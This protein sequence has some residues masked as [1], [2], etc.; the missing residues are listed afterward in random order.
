M[1][2]ASATT[3][4]IIAL[5]SLEIVARLSI[6]EAELATL[7][8]GR[9]VPRGAGLEGER[10]LLN[11]VDEIALAAGLAA[12]PVYV[13]T[14][15]RGINA[16]AAGRSPNQAIV[17]V[18]QGALDQLSRDELQAVVAHEF[19]HIIN[20]DIR[21]NLRAACVLQGI[22]FLSAIGRF[23]MRY[24]SGYGT[25]EGRRF[26]H[27]P[28][29]A[30]GAGIF[31]IGAIGLPLARWIQ[32]AISRE[33]E[34]LADA[35]AVR[36]TRNADALCGA[37]ARIETNSQGFR[38]LNWHGDAMA[39]MLFAAASHPPIESR[40]Q[41]VNPHLPPE[42][43]YEQARK[44]A[45]PEKKRVVAEQQKPRTIV[46]KKATA[47]AVLVASLGEP[48]PENLEH[49]A[50]L[51]AYLPEGWKP[52]RSPVVERMYSLLIGAPGPWSNV[53]RFH[54]LYGNAE[55][56][57]RTLELGS[58]CEAFETDLQLYVA[59]AARHRVFVHAGVVGWQGQAIV[60]PGRSFSGKSTTTPPA[61]RS[62]PRCAP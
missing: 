42:H 26:F 6:G 53:R 31:A 10:R 7:L 30:L 50:G 8:M 24:Y 41:R 45:P 2:T 46:P 49:A 55:R 5:G 44:P 40:M 39:H 1:R 52:A 18:T 23:M 47:V 57:A 20:G 21:L 51:L 28:F 35:S 27:L 37:L 56:L 14:R 33:R 61:R 32:G 43:F 15:E 19:S 58:L 25:E 9:R 4:A 36:Y 62:F 11:V 48:T 3:L 12:P 17:V 34:Y 22:V 59:Q 16:F 54:L 13:L 38:L 60:I 29:A